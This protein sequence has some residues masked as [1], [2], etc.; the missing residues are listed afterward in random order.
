MPNPKN[1]KPL[2]DQLRELDE[3][4]AWF[5]QDDFDLDE[6]LKRFD[7]GVKLTEAIE[8]RLSKLENKITV[9]KQRFGEGGLEKAQ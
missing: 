6:A 7:E 9:L 1:E 4:I 2:S 3:L 8:E 5:D